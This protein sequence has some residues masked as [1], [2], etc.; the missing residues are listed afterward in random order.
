MIAHEISHGF[1]DVGRKFDSSGL[2]KNWWTNETLFN[3]TA[4]S[5]CFI[6]QYNGFYE[7]QV[8]FRIYRRKFKL[9]LRQ[10]LF[11]D[12]YQGEQKR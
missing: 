4:K 12:F 10:I 3:Y 1:D 11:I 6:D 8:S 7:A 9:D 2:L 5:W